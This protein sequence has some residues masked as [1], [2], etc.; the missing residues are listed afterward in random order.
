M[1]HQSSDVEEE[2]ATLSASSLIGTRI[3]NRSGEDLGRLEELRIDLERGCVAYAVLSIGGHLRI[4]E[5]WFAVPWKALQIDLDNEYIILDIDRDSLE[6][7]PGIDKD[8]PPGARDEDWLREVYI[9]YGH[10]PYWEGF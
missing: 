8:R 3:Q 6:N 9:Y 4:D 5:K 10:T 7:A 2:T 1:P